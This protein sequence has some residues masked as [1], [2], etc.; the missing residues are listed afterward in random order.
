VAICLVYIGF[1][2]IFTKIKIIAFS[3]L[4]WT[5]IYYQ[6]P[7]FFSTFLSVSFIMLLGLS[8]NPCLY[9]GLTLLFD[10]IITLLIP[11]IYSVIKI[12]KIRLNSKVKEVNMEN[13]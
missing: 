10:G 13:K 11:I 8:N 4:G 3:I 2:E 12:H 1:Q 9:V 7:G 5:F 6:N